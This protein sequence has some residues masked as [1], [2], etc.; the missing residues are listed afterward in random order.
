MRGHNLFE[1]HPSS[2]DPHNLRRRLVSHACNHRAGSLNNPGGVFQQS[3]EMVC[4]LLLTKRD[5][6]VEGE[7]TQITVYL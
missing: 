5:V 1:S 4:K 2:K 6:C 7:A 3:R